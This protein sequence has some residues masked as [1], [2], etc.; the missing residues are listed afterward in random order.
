MSSL[1]DLG[2]V[3]M[4]IG[5]IVGLI[6]A[7]VSLAMVPFMARWMGYGY[8]MVWQYGGIMVRYAMFG[9]PDFGLDMMSGVMFVWSLLGLAG[10]LLSI[11]CGLKLRQRHVKKIA[12]I[13]IIG[14]IILLLTFSWLPA[15]SVLAGSIMM[16]IE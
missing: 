1:K 2:T 5:G 8:A 16:Y 10:A 3:L 9:Y 7:S 4:L 6:F 12:V 11:Y 14:G 13:G 15:F